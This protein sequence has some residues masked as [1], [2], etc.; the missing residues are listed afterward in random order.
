MRHLPGFTKHSL[1][2]NAKFKMQTTRG[3]QQPVKGAATFTPLL[4]TNRV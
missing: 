1:I 3:L 2:Q 4:I